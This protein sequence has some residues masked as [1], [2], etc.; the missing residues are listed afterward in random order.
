M[1]IIMATTGIGT[2]TGVIGVKADEYHTQAGFC[3]AFC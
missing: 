1:A 3:P 2:G